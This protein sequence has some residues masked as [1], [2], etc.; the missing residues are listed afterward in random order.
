MKQSRF[1]LILAV[2]ICIAAVLAELACRAFVTPTRLEK[3]L[4]IL[5][6][7]P[8]LMWRL[9]AGLDVEFENSRVR[10]NEHRLRGPAFLTTKITGQ[11]RIVCMGAS[12]TFGWGVEEN[13][14]Y[15]AVL[16]EELKK[17]G[18][19]AE[20][21]NGG[22]PGYT[23]WQGLRWLRRDALGWA[24]DLVTV[25]YD[26]NDLDRY[27]FFNNDGRPDSQQTPSSP[28][29][30]RA[31]NIANR[32]AAYRLFRRVLLSLADKGGRADAEN[33]PRRVSLEEYKQNL[34]ALEL[35][36]R[37]EKIEVVFLKMPINLPFDRL[38]VIDGEKAARKR[39][40]GRTEA[41]RGDIAAAISSYEEAQRLDPTN[42]D[43]YAALADVYEMDGRHESAEK[44]RDLLPFVASFRDRADGLYNLAVEVVA[45]ETERPLADIIAAFQKDGRGDLLWNSAEDPFHPNANGHRI[46]G[47]VISEIVEPILR[48]KLP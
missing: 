32:S 21:I 12:P 16:R 39:N 22:V 31:Q 28:L 30:A 47:N 1:S 27:R 17:R 26:L 33:L 8:D 46:I 18:V 19:I 42:L 34:A 6:R 24:P 36:C 10:I 43:A 20:V 45:G 37:R 29:L 5:E 4:S 41:D 48:E 11:A 3:I 25:A 9:G 44:M 38:Q 13:D 7:D 2:L 35:A 23:S 15:P 40:L 14:A